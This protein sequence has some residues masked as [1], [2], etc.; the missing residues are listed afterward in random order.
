MSRPAD[1]EMEGTLG[2]VDALSYRRWVV[3]ERKKYEE[4]K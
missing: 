4:R 2:F 3:K 1:D